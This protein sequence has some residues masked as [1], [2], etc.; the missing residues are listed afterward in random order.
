MQLY[1]TYR[2]WENKLLH[3]PSLKESIDL[4]FIKGFP[5][6]SELI[7][8][9]QT[10]IYFYKLLYRDNRTNI[11]YYRLD[12]IIYILL[13]YTVDSLVTDVHRM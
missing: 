5:V 4:T 7:E 13:V 8:D 3:S 6:V 9:K 1:L 12:A 10:K 11:L 2:S